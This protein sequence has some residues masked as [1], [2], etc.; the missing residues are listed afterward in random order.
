MRKLIA[1]LIGGGLFIYGLLEIQ[2]AIHIITDTSG[3]M[4]GFAVMLIGALL[5]SVEISRW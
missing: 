1:P 2:D 5:L 3:I 4:L